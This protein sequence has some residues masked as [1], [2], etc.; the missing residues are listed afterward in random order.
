M[1]ALIEASVARAADRV[2]VTDGERSVTYG[3][4]DVRANQLAHK[5]RSVVVEKGAPVALYM[6]RSIDAIVGLLGIL[7]SGSPYVPMAADLPAPR[8]AQRIAE[9]GIGGVVSLSALAEHV[10][11]GVPTICL[12]SDA[13]ALSTES[14]MRPD[15]VIAPDSLAYILYTSGSTG[16][17]KGVGIT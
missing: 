6:D 3:E 10:P 1:T 2:A 14:V 7:R 13:D 4:L 11:T 9:G 15:V 8:L 12:D 17:P 5:L 16:V